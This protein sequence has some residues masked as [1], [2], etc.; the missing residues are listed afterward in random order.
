MKQRGNTLV[1]TL[2]VVAIIL[3]LV[4]VFMKPNIGGLT[5]PTTPPRKDNKGKTT[6]G[7]AKADA[8]DEVCKANLG[9]VRQ[10]IQV[11]EASDSDA[12]PA[13]LDELRLPASVTHCPI[14]NEAY[15]YDSASGTVH[16]PHPG[17][18]KY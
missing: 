18:E 14:G 13:S 7:L 3:V 8:Q 9:Q 11:A 2:V 10:S 16:C 12:H 17:H 1:A 4:V 6:L 5:A 15:T